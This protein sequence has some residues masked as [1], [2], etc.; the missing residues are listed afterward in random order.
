MRKPFLEKGVAVVDV[1]YS[2]AFHLFALECSRDSEAK[3]N[4]S[5]TWNERRIKLINRKVTTTN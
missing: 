1:D 4:P 5:T 2:Q 3:L